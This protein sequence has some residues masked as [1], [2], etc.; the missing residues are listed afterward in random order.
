KKD[1]GQWN[2]TPQPGNIIYHYVGLNR[3][4]DSAELSRFRERLRSHRL[5]IL[6]IDRGCCQVQTVPKVGEAIE[7]FDWVCAVHLKPVGGA[8]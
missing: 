8:A 4:G 7:Y 2:P 5:R 6:A 1:S 3:K